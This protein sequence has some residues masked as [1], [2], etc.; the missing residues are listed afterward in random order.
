MDLV[1]IKGW[2]LIELTHLVCS[3]TQLL[4]AP[5]QSKNKWRESQENSVKCFYPALVVCSLTCRVL[6]LLATFFSF[7]FIDKTSWSWLSWSRVKICSQFFWTLSHRNQRIASFSFSFLFT[8]FNRMLKVFL[9]CQSFVF[10]SPGEAVNKPGT[11]NISCLVTAH[12]FPAITPGPVW[13]FF[14][15]V[16]STAL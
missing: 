3:N 7:K 4:W 9:L 16:I 14:S 8:A 12:D 1:R 6:S 5:S 13:F 10:L 2:L 11:Q 15:S